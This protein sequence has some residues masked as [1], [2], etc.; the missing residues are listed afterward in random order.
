ME[1]EAGRN[2]FGGHERDEI[3]K[4]MRCGDVAASTRMDLTKKFTFPAGF[5]RARGITQNVP[6]LINVS[7][8]EEH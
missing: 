6:L 3:M 4:G 5:Q 7:Q 2:I 1:C 8:I